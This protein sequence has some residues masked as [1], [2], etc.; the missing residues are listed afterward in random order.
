MII[1][2]GRKADVFDRLIA[3]I[4]NIV[5]RENFSMGE[6]RR[7]TI[8]TVIAIIISC[9]PLTPDSDRSSDIPHSGM[10]KILSVGRS[11]S[12][13]WNNASASYDEKPGM[14]T[15]F[16]YDYW[17]DSTEVTQKQ[18]YEE[19]GRRP[20]DSIS[21]YGAGDNY[22]IYRVSWF[23][24]VLYCNARSRREGLDTVYMYSGAKALTNGTVYEL[25]GLRYDIC[26]DG[27]RLPTEAEW[28][29]AAR[30]ASSVLPYSSIADSLYACFYTWHGKNSSGRTHTVG[31]RLPNSLGLYDMAGNVFEWTNDWKCLYT[32]QDI[33]NSL[34]SLQ[35]SREYE[36]VIKG[37]SY[38]YSQMYLRPSHRSATYATM[39][40]SAN[41]YVGFRCA[42]GVIPNG[43]YIGTAR[44][45]FTP[46]PVDITANFNDLFFFL[47]TSEMKLV[48]VNVTGLNR[49]LCCIDF[50]RMFPYVQEYLD[51]REVYMP[52]LSP[53]GRYAAYCSRNEGQSEPSK[54]SVRRMDSLNT[55]IVRLSAD[56]AYI[57]RWWVKPGSEDTC[58][59]YTNSAIDNED[60]RWKTTK[61]FV[62]KMSGGK[63]IGDREELI[64][65]GSYH[66][67][68]S[69]D[70]RY[71]VTGYR[72]LLR[73]ELSG[74]VD[75]QLFMP[76]GNGKDDSG[77]TQV[78]NASIS[79]D[80]R[81]GV[82]CMFLDFGYPRASG[83]TGCSYGVHEYLF[84]SDVKG[85]ITN[86]LHCP[87]GEQSWDG[88][89]W[90]NE[91]RFGVGCGRNPSNQAHAVYAIDLEGKA[92]K[93]LV[94]GT[95]LQQPHLWITAAMLSND[96]L[97]RYNDPA[98][99]PV[100]A[101]QML[102]FWWHFNAI[103]ILI[104]GSSHSYVGIN[105]EKIDGYK[106]FNIGAVG[107]DLLWEIHTTLNYAL[108][109]CPNLKMI[110]SSLDMGFLENSW[111]DR[112]WGQGFGQSKG[113]NYDST[114]SFWKEGVTTDFIYKIKLVSPPIPFPIEISSY[115]GYY[116]VVCNNWGDSLPPHEGFST[117]TITDSVYQR[118]LKTI[119]M[120]ADTLRSRGIHWT[121]I[122]FPV[123][124]HY[125]GTDYY[126][127]WGPS[128]QTARDI[129]QQMRN[130]EASNTFFHLYDAN[131]DGNH[132]YGDE[133]ARDEDHL[134]GTGAN[135]L[136]ARLDTLIDSI[137]KR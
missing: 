70:G 17:L 91:V 40:S 130:I 126:S 10:K 19:M 20:V 44:S 122:N 43:Q 12:Q 112:Q 7:G 66:D 103:E 45:A 56:T 92:S 123:S 83:V 111:R 119:T 14:Q 104:N 67:G 27:Y 9:A 37:G 117:W 134:C 89:E 61:T 86:Y 35:P 28:E 108:N 131:M 60:F 1:A 30:E 29:Y 127:Y 41:E 62:Q 3:S 73:R 98:S 78:C 106:A 99:Q 57:P 8:F 74:V 114:H 46:N 63:P 132:D 13:G 68:I 23:D 110:C 54:V 135:K 11:F 16:T 115:A 102:A 96:S 129:L 50:S 59:V 133:E 105:P 116:P 72:E 137:L 120:I 22:P 64:S 31:T 113:Y 15:A 125:K 82:R 136:T 79:P 124:P 107:G 24:A 49:T 25:T 80:G 36:K 33:T 34:G 18:Y 51:D 93:Q 47:G 128:W 2:E 109:L 97:G 55:V 94:T 85:H 95:E 87:G 48:F 5:N 26:R 81:D 53:D 100:L 52:V 71:A 101:M 69:L 75:T 90:T 39:Q 6:A 4:V 42:R 84:V 38:N 76:P 65:N 118:N 77:S 121:M 88:V 32:G 21:A 58:I